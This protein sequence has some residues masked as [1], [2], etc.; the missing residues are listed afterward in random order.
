MYFLEG[1]FEI[2]DY[3]TTSYMYECVAPLRALLLQKT[4][5]AKYKKVSF[6]RLFYF[7]IIP[8]TFILKFIRLRVIIK[9]FFYQLV[10][11]ESHVNERKKSEEW[12]QKVKENVIGVMKKTL[13]I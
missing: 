5:P 3:N 10:S 11:L 4:A 1:T 9:F 7:T 8:S 2:E 6:A 12:N 13:G